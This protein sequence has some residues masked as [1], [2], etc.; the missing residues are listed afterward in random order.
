M[1]NS[2]SWMYASIHIDTE[3]AT[4][5]LIFKAILLIENIFS[6]LD[7]FESDRERSIGYG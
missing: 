1:E 6:N 2:D 4:K 7:A 3:K 5:G